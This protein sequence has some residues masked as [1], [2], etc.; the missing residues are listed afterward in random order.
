MLV[1]FP[2]SE[3]TGMA[4]SKLSTTDGRE[5]F[6]REQLRGQQSSGQGVRE[7]CQAA[8]LSVPSFYWWRQELRIRDS[9]RAANERPKFV[10]IQMTPRPASIDFIEVVLA[11]GRL[12]RVGSDFDANHLRAVVAALEPAPC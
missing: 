7:F 11:S 2:V 10:P 12:I 1:L 8:G 3:G 6:W 4:R 5:Q 9:R